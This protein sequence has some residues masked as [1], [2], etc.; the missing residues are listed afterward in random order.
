MRLVRT[1][2]PDKAAMIAAVLLLLRSEA[3][4]GEAPPAAESGAQAPEDSVE[5]TPLLE[6]GRGPKRR[7]STAA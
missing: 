3:A 5:H 7:R 1:Y 4:P 6:T 2:Q